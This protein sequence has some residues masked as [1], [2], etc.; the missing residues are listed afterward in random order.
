MHQAVENSNFIVFDHFTESVIIKHATRRTRFRDAALSR[1][2]HH[3][4]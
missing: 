2:I 3:A 1:T 4:L